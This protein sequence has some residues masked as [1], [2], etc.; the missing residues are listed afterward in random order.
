LSSGSAA[1]GVLRHRY[2]VT[3]ISSRTAVEWKLTCSCKRRIG[4]QFY[5]K[6]AVL[7]EFM[8]LKTHIFVQR[9]YGL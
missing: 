8:Q 4:E 5:T 7:N 6:S 3:T 9:N 1:A 2:R